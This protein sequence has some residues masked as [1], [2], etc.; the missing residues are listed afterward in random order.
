SKGE[1]VCLVNSDVKFI[2][3]CFT[4]M[5]EHMRTHPNVAMLG[6][7]MLATDRTVRRSTMRFPTIWNEFCRAVCLDLL[8]KNSPTFGGQ[9]MADFNHTKTSDVEVLNGWFWMVSR[10]VV[11]EV[12]PLD[13]QFFMYGEDI[14]WCY[15]FHK[16]GR[17]IVFFAG[18]EAIHYGGASSSA[19]PMRFSVE[20][21]RGTR[22]FLRK[23]H[24][25]I[26]RAGLFLVS[27]TY[28][29]LRAIGYGALSVLKRPGRSEAVLK[30]H[31]SIAC[32]GWLVRS[33]SSSG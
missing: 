8:F 24:S 22:Q 26:S 4:P 16:A 29:G 11:A 30:F 15:R 20:L 10:G 27:L 28:H 9:L 25:A 18:A 5:I 12:G 31:R 14:D 3:D 17:Q 7:K 1:Y 13:E 21:E 23:H 6:P 2:H 32:L 33:R 19:A